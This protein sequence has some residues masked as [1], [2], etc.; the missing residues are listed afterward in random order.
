MHFT[1]N[2]DTCVIFFFS[3]EMQMNVQ[4]HGSAALPS[5]KGPHVAI[6]EKLLEPRDRC[7]R[8]KN[9]RKLFVLLGTEHQ[10]LGHPVRNPLP[11]RLSYPDPLY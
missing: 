4:A 5:V 11:F 6:R 10:F 2:Q 3:L 1:K 9:R 7:G 8:C